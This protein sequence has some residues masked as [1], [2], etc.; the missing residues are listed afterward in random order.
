M[1]PKKALITGITLGF[2][3][4]MFLSGCAHQIQVNPNVD[5]IR[6][7]QGIETS[8]MN[9]GYYIPKQEML[10]QVN[11]PGGGGDSVTY[12]PYQ[13]AE[14][15]LNAVLSKKFSRVFSIKSLEDT[16][17]IEEKNLRY[18]FMT[19]ATKNN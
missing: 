19:S 7:A 13:D 17:Y 10:K 5:D 14:P 2:I 8:A 4:F 15:A 11:T 6:G 12:E 9:V 1:L 18:I 3:S 16:A